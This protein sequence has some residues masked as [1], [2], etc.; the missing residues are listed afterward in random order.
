MSVLD[1]H[2]ALVGFMGA[3]KT[4]LGAEVARRIGRRFVDLD[5]LV[6]S[7]AERSIVELFAEGESR[8]RELEARAAQEMLTSRPP[9]VLAL[10]GGALADDRT[11]ELLREHAVAVWLDES[12]EA[13]WARTRG[14]D[15][16]L[17]R[18]RAEFERLYHER[19]DAYAEIADATARDAE[20]AVLAATGVHVERGAVRRL[21]ALVPGDG[22]AALV[23]DP[24]VAGI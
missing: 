24:H 19:R 5:E 4:T 10:G 11:R 20:D 18:D 7:R 9:L 14:S 2:L 15:R 16:P 6:E 17:A 12:L 23:S 3:G 21:A 1:R 22:P 8:F 13:C